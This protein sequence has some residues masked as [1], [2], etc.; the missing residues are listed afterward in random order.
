MVVAQHI[1]ISGRGEARNKPPI[2]WPIN[3]Q[4][5]RQEYAMGK[6]QFLQQMVFGKSIAT[7]KYKKLDPF[8]TPYT[9][10][11]LKMD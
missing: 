11:K 6:R 7:H 3:L 4:Q 5:K 9:Q 1:E 8:L 10:K 2:I